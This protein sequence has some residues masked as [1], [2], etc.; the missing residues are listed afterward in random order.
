MAT[1]GSYQL[2]I[3]ENRKKHAWAW[4]QIGSMNSKPLEGERGSARMGKPR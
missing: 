4:N 2:S 1:K 3:K